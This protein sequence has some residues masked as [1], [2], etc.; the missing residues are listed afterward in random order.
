[1]SEL[2]S[3][4]LVT[5]AAAL[6]AL[7]VPADAIGSTKTDPIFAAIEAHRRV[8]WV[9]FARCSDL[10]MAVSEGEEAAARTLAEIIEAVDA[11]TD[12]LIDTT[13]TTNASVAALLE[14]AAD[15][16]VRNGTNCWPRRL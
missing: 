16:T 3:R 8:W 15:H 13:P 4:G 10:D 7:A 2:S 6:P 1:M 11:A 5:T 9:D 14:Y 12:P